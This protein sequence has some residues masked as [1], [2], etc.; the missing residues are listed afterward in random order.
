MVL[1]VVAS[2]AAET[3]AAAAFGLAFFGDFG[4]ELPLIKDFFVTAMVSIPQ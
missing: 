3:A 2:L 1:N 4:E